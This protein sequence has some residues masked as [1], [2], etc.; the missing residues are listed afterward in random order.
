[1]KTIIFLT[2]IILIFSLNSCDWFL[3]GDITT[4]TGVITNESNEPLDS[5]KIELFASGYSIL[6]GQHTGITTEYAYTNSKGEYD[7]KFSQTENYEYMIRPKFAYYVYKRGESIQTTCTDLKEGRNQ[8][9]NLVLKKYGKSTIEGV[10]IDKNTQSI[11]KNVK[12]I[13]TEYLDTTKI[14]ATT[15]TDNKG[16][17]KLIFLQ[18][19][20]FEEFYIIPELQNYSSHYYS[21]FIY[22]D[23]TKTINLE[24]EKIN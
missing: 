18:K 17:Y 1:M 15:Y 10:V 3:K 16:Y 20:Y 6:S 24:M 2:T 23:K 22:P 9:I 19:Y 12:I 21:R 5:V 14:L 8:E 13:V 11:L 4:V 7:L